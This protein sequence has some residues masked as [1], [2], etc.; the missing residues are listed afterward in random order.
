[1]HCFNQNRL[2]IFSSSRYYTC[3]TPRNQIPLYQPSSSPFMSLATINSHLWIA[4][5]CLLLLLSF[6]FFKSILFYSLMFSL[7]PGQIPTHLSHITLKTLSSTASLCLL[8]PDALVLYLSCD[9]QEEF[10]TISISSVVSTASYTS[11]HGTK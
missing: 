4:V 7:W 6:L 10:V 9:P 5:L 3:N 1:M 11:R 8:H 2:Y